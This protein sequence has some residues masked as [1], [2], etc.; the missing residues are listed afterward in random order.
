MI[1]VKRPSGLAVPFEP[2]E[3]T[4]EAAIDRSWEVPSE[5]CTL[6]EWIR[7]PYR[8]VQPYGYRVEVS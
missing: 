2:P 7:P 1:T 6:L 3:I 4:V 8:T 5:T